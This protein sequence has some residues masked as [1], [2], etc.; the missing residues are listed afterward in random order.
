MPLTIF[1]VVVLKMCEFIQRFC[2]PDILGRLFQRSKETANLIAESRKE[3]EV[4]SFRFT[5]L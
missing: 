2:L 1:I 4:I 5:N 3:Y